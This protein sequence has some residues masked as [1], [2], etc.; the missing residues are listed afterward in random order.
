MRENRKN[1]GV[2]L[3]HELFIWQQFHRID[4]CFVA[5]QTKGCV[6]LRVLLRIEK[7]QTEV[8]DY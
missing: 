7:L 1:R 5:A 4:D 2:D 6:A 8:Q 3:G